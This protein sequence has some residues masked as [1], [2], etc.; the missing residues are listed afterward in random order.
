MQRLFTRSGLGVMAFGVMATLLVSACS[1]AAHS[2]SKSSSGGVVTFAETPGGNPDYILPLAGGP[3]FSIAND[4]LFSNIMYVPLYSFGVGAD[5]VLNKQLSIADPPVFSDGNTV[6]TVNLKHWVW[7]NGTPITS[8]DVVFWM[9]LLSAV[10]DPNA[11]VI[12]SSSAPGPGWGAEVPGAFPFNVES[13][14]A[15]GTYQV[16]FK[17]NASYNPTWFTYN[18]LSQI[19]PLPQASWDRL[20]ASGSVG[21]YDSSAQAR[22]AVSGTSP[23]Q[24]IPATAGTATSGAL[25]VAQFLNSASQDLS[26]Y[27]TDP[28]WQVASGPFI[29]NQ[30]TTSGFVKMVPNRQYSGSP[31]PTISAFEELPFTSDTSEFNAVHNG[32]VTIGYVPT[33]DL[34]QVSQL[35]KSAGYKYNPWY[36]FSSS[37]WNYNFT[38]PTNGDIVKQ[39]YF[40]QAV[41]S[42]VNQPQYIK[43]FQNGLGLPT[44][45]PVPTYPAH[46]PDVSP[47]EAGGLIYPYDPT[48]AVSLLRDHGWTVVPGG[49]SYCSKPGTGAGECGAGITLD[50]KA[51]FTALYASGNT[52]LQSEMESF[53][54]TEQKYAG[55]H[56]QIQGESGTEMAGVVTGCTYAHPCSSWDLENFGGS[57]WVYS[58]DYLPTGGELFASGAASNLGDYTSATAVRL[59]QETHTA[60]TAAAEQKALFAY[61]D[62]IA[63]QLPLVN[64]PS[65][66]TQATV[67]KSNLSGFVPQGVYETLSPQYYRF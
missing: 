17:L 64:W 23:V 37:D 25:G 27:T 3:Y 31:K 58:P 46:N 63:Q 14:R 52:E 57:G 13:Y 62:Y 10:T 42:L 55:I 40:R 24:Y 50:Q 2:S 18:E 36:T 5:P 67:Y 59:I 30:F 29:L 21:D 60:P 39:L 8:R 45:G 65:A 49:T 51:D 66:F 34:G 26:T 12:G 35:E 28:L 4:S 22:Q 41:Q 15:T 48:K 33:Q 56:W 38:N 11:P 20:S 47:L 6:V 16:Q 43:D 54:S 32:S 53:Q 19:T 44:N 9:N 61:E 1:G 7:S